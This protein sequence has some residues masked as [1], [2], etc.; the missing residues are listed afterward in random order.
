MIFQDNKSNFFGQY[1]ILKVINSYNT[2][3][4]LHNN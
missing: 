4:S 2:L 3:I 1:D